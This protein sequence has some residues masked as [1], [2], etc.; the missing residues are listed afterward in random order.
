MCV[1][2]SVLVCA[3]V[4]THVFVCVYDCMCLSMLVCVC[5]RACVCMCMCV[6]MCVDGIKNMTPKTTPMFIEEDCK[7]I[8]SMVGH[9]SICISCFVFRYHAVSLFYFVIS[10]FDHYSYVLDQIA[11]VSKLS[12]FTM[13]NLLLQC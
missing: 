8:I 6:C 1:F 7:L 3:G 2:L 4:C 13:E 10:D 9:S 5:V 12:D 11:R